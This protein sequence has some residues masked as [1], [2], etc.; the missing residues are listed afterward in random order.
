MIQIIHVPS[1]SVGNVYAI[2]TN[3]SDFNFDFARKTAVCKI[4][5]TSIRKTLLIALSCLVVYN[6]RIEIES[7]GYYS[8]CV[9]FNF[10]QTLL[11]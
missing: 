9:C 4:K 6:T 7:K 3:S 2:D 1:K 11:T 10:Q 8:N 5:L